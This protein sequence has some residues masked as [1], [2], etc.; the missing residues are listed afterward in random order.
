MLKG[1]GQSQVNWAN[2]GCEEGDVLEEAGLSNWWSQLS[3]RDN[4]LG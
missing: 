4:R 3:Y 2:G 1:A